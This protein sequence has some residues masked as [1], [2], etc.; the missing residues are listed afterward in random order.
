MR[1][2]TAE[3]VAYHEAGHAVVALDLGRT[4]KSL[5]IKATE[6]YLGCCFL[7]SLPS[8]RPDVHIDRW[9]SSQSERLMMICY[10]GAAAERI[11]FGRVVWAGCEDDMKVAVEIAQRECGCEDEVDA[12]C[13][14]MKIRARQT[15]L[16]IFNWVAVEQIATALLETGE[17]RYKT[18]KS[19]AAK[20][21]T[22]VVKC[23]KCGDDALEVDPAG[24]RAV[25]IRHAAKR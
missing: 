20:A 3:R 16:Q 2:P 15:L 8:Y 18:V 19:I 1:I 12:L 9:T 14:L 23:K 17:L 7:R 11:A 24:G 4:F 10:A 25:C 13:R 5:T 21:M 6:D 22:A